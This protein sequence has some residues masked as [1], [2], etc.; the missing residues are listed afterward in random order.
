MHEWSYKVFKLPDS[1][2]FLFFG[3]SLLHCQSGNHLQRVNP[4]KGTTF[5][6]VELIQKYNFFNE[7]YYLVVVNGSH[8]WGVTWYCWKDIYCKGYSI[9][10]TGGGRKFS[11]TPSDKIGIFST[12]WTKT[13]IFLTPLGHKSDICYPL[14]HA[15][16]CD[17]QTV[18]SNFT[19][20][21]AD[22]FLS[23]FSPIIPP[24]PLGQFILTFLPPQTFSEKG[25]EVKLS[26]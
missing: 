8:F 10:K 24:P 12:A 1:R 4:K 9:K 13:G 2:E 17:P 20:F 5:V 3:E 15:S 16:S 18:L 21:P 11:V 26:K 14:G 19:V 22:S 23:I 25:E 7:L 6:V